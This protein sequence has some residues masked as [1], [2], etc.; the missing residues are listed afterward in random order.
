VSPPSTVRPSGIVA[1]T[2]RWY[3]HRARRPPLNSAVL[4]LSERMDQKN[5]NWNYR[6]IQGT[7]LKLGH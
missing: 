5:S 3:R 1:H 2:C 4:A 7:L 6:R